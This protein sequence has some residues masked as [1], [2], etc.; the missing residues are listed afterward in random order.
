ME[1]QLKGLFARLSAAKIFWQV[2]TD[3]LS[4]AIATEDHCVRSIMPNLDYV[5]I[6]T[7]FMFMRQLLAR[8]WETW[9]SFLH[10]LLITEMMMCLL[11]VWCIHNSERTS[12]R[13]LSQS[14]ELC[15]WKIDSAT[16]PFSWS[17]GYVW[18]LWCVWRLSSL[19]FIILAT[20]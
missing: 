13:A 20:W 5:S 17:L 11:E 18:Q 14:K 10:S 7:V 3:Q 2:I 15:R 6:A 1:S 9:I 12:F 8:F 4:V 16:G 19:S